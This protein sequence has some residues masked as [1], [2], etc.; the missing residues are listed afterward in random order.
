MNYSLV[1]V[2]PLEKYY[3][4]LIFKNGS[5]AMVNMEN[6]IHTLRFSQLASPEFFRT[7][8]VVGDK[9]IWSDGKKNVGIYTNEILD[10]MMLD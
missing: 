3:L 6:R 5:T 8:K 9:I 2:Y 10:I 1:S 4:R 7:V